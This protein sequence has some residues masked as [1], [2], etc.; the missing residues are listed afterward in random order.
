M[1]NARAL[2][3]RGNSASIKSFSHMFF[4]ACYAVIFGGFLTDQ[5]SYHGERG[6]HAECHL[7]PVVPVPHVKIQNR[8]FA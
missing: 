7:V 5:I 8:H 6:E 3:A 2:V 4:L 1:K